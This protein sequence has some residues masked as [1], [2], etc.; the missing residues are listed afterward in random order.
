MAKVPVRLQLAADEAAF[1]ALNPYMNFSVAE[2]QG[3]VLPSRAATS[4]ASRKPG[5]V[6]VWTD[7]ACADHAL[8]PS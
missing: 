8:E 4:G 7:K 3:F 6:A 5:I 2:G 1:K